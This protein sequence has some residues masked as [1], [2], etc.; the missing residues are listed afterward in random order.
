MVAASEATY[1]AIIQIWFIKLQRYLPP[2]DGTESSADKPS[3]AS[4][5]DLV[6]KEA[7]TK[8][9]ECSNAAE[10]KGTQNVVIPKE[11]SWEEDTEQSSASGGPSEYYLNCIE[12]PFLHSSIP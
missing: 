4:N 7:E 2:T 1:Q 11:E 9:T 10:N 5:I 12:W 3:E 8:S 6:G